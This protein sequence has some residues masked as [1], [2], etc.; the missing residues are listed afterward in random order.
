MLKITGF[1]ELGKSLD[2][3]QKA[4]AA[5]DGDIASVNFDPSDPESIEHAVLAAYASIDERVAPFIR[6][7]MVAELA[8]DF[9]EV[10]RQAILD[11]A[12][13]ARLEEN[14]EG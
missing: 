8:A 7:E 12:A 1:D 3:L 2:E 14:D 5:L 6:N 10:A 11:R 4:T 13:A 9:K